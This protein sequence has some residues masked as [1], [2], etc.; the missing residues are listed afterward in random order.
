MLESRGSANT[1]WG[2]AGGDGGK[3]RRR[4]TTTV[5]L[6]FDCCRD[7]YL[8]FFGFWK[9][10]HD[11]HRVSRRRPVGWFH[12]GVSSLS[13]VQLHFNNFKHRARE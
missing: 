3:Y 6:G 13:D 10:W 12:G 5:A 9:G 4:N 11:G 1:R 8:G 7:V 2:S